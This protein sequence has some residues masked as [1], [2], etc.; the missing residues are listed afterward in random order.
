MPHSLSGAGNHIR[1]GSRRTS[2]PAL[3]HES[4]DRTDGTDCVLM[5]CLGSEFGQCM[6]AAS[7]AQSARVCPANGTFAN[8]PTPPHK[9]RRNAR[10][11]L[12]VS[13]SGDNTLMIALV[14]VVVLSIFRLL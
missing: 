12:A 8:Y 6:C 13:I 1:L 9:L 2:L 4:N 7:M 3:L 10:N 11:T 14:N 5:R